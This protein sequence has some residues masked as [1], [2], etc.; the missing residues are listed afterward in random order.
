M[1]YIA[2]AILG[3]AI[4]WFLMQPERP[5]PQ[6]V[7]EDYR[8]EGFAKDAYRMELSLLMENYEIRKEIRTLENMSFGYSRQEAEAEAEQH[9]QEEIEELKQVIGFLL[10]PEVPDAVPAA[11]P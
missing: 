9:L 3:I 6:F 10:S 1:K 8:L 11:A 4:A 7:E 5:E 2:P